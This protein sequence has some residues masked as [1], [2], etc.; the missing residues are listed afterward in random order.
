MA[1]PTTEVQGCVVG[2]VAKFRS[3][4]ELEART[5]KE[6]IDMVNKSGMARWTNYD[7]EILAKIRL[8]DG[9]FVCDPINDDI[10]DGALVVQRPCYGCRHQGWMLLWMFREDKRY[11]HPNCIIVECLRCRYDY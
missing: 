5:R 4:K 7:P 6:L 1:T 3:G 10:L 11:I 8:S 2:F 9:S